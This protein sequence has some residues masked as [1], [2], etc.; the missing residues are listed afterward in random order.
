VRLS[1]TGYFRNFFQ[2]LDLIKIVAC[3]CLAFAVFV[4]IPD[5][6][7][8]L[9]RYAA[10][11]LA[12]SR[13]EL[14]HPASL[15]EAIVSL[16]SGPIAAMLQAFDFKHPEGL[17]E[18]LTLIL[19]TSLLSAS[20]LAAAS[21][22]YGLNARRDRSAAA[23]DFS[24]SVFLLVGCI[25]S[26]AV[27]L[28][29]LN[30]RIDIHSPQ[31]RHAMLAGAK[32]SF[33]KDSA[34]LGN[35]PL[36]PDFIDKI[37]D[38]EIS[39]Q[40][41]INAW[42]LSGAVALL[43][44]TAV[45]GV[46]SYF[47]FRRPP[48]AVDPAQKG[49]SRLIIVGLGSP[50]LLSLVFVLFPVGLART[51]T[52]FVVICLFFAVMTLFIAALS[53]LEKRA[54][55]PLLFLLVACAAA[56]NL[57]GLNYN[58]KVRQLVDR[59]PE[60]TTSPQPVGDGFVQWLK[61]RLDLDRYD[62]YPVY[63]VA[64]EGG[65]IYAAFRTAA[66]LASLQD[67]CPRFSHHLFAISS[68]SGG[69]IGAAVFSGLTQKIK[70]GDERL[71]AGRG[72]AGNG[73]AGRHL[74]FTDVAEDILRDDFLSPVL[75]AFL[76]PDFLQRFLFFPIPQFDRAI[77]L[78]KSLETS[79]DQRTRDYYALFPDNWV[80]HDNPLRG[81]FGK[82]WDPRS[83]SP[84]LFINT[85][86]VDS[87]R[88]RV[89]TPF[90]LDTEELSSLPVYPLL[91]AAQ[92]V[93][94]D[95]SMSTAAVL[96]AR[97]PLLTPPGLVP[98]PVASAAAAG[99]PMPPPRNLQ[100]VDG[101]YFDN[102]GVITALAVMREMQNAAAQIKNPKVQINLIV[103]TSTDFTNPVTLGDYLAP[104]QTLLNTRAARGLI[105]IRQAE[106]FFKEAASTSQAGAPADSLGEAV[107]YGY[108]YPLPLGW[109]L[110]PIT[111][112]LILGQMGDKMLCKSGS[113]D[114]DC[115]RAKMYGDLDK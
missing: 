13:I 90:A 83:D 115:L 112:L 8:E 108:G 53:L 106:R 43:G 65:G 102:S 113:D 41:Q 54:R 9:Y 72:C 1:A 105:A 4:I 48:K 15:T 104:F 35:V 29:L 20:F 97:F 99:A 55:A 12:N 60:H 87:G 10:Q 100:L 59:A 47:L 67:L 34:A 51:L 28:G 114:A 103:L 5:Q 91:A 19:S 36:P 62:T 64:A 2:T 57:L 52:A 7:L 11:S 42:L 81:S 45:F 74:F 70:Q 37:A 69:S 31:L 84:A 49:G 3:I 21:F 98:M 50:V 73:E 95:M 76:F 38:F 82:G 85:T 68:V 93:G 16:L 86:E 14:K 79:W 24:T 25:P 88:E 92:Q 6:S 63:V 44:L 26:L 110:S 66:F 27:G 94:I 18:G 17:I 46:V 77:A 75:A 33:E 71:Q 23:A 111:R 96:S 32:L 101:G 109:R 78:E 89:I 40:F 30:A 22:L 56:F 58:H 107:L 39:S 80:D 61:F